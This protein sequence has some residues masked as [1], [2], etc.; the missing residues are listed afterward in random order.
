M[1]YFKSKEKQKEVN[2]DKIHI[3]EFEFENVKVYAYCFPD[4]GFTA[5][6]IGLDIFRSSIFICYFASV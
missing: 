1:A 4:E 5:S 2:V 3:E 6:A